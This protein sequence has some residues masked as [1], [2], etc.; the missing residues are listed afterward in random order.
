MVGMYKLR[1]LVEADPPS[2]SKSGMYSMKRLVD[3]DPAAGIKESVMPTKEQLAK[4]DELMKELSEGDRK[5]LQDLRA[6]QLSMLSSLDELYHQVE[7][8]KTQVGIKYLPKDIVDSIQAS[9]FSATVCSTPAKLDDLVIR[10]VVV[11]CHPD[12]PPLALLVYFEMLKLHFK[13]IGNVH[14][15]SSA[16]VVPPS[17]SASLGGNGTGPAPLNCGIA[18]A[19]PLRDDYQIAFTL[20]WKDVSHGPEMMV[21]PHRQARIRG[22]SSI[23]RYFARLCHPYDDAEATEATEI[24]T[25]TDAAKYTSEKDFAAYLKSLSSRLSGRD[26]IIGNSLTI[27]DIVNWAAIKSATFKTMIP[28]SVESWKKRC[29]GRP[30]FQLAIRVAQHKRK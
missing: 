8:L 20:I 11:N 6:K 25:W 13:V 3:L 23:C 22:E 16:G 21:A 1:P 14:T 30:E 24:D 19:A 12:T 26:W 7:D 17:L 5:A 4:E 28:P 18:S 10:D 15:H 27:A 29:E 2:E 9:L